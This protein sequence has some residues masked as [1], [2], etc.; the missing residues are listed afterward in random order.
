MVNNTL[1]QE[2]LRECVMSDDIAVSVQNVSKRYLL[3][4][5][6]QD[7]LKQSLFWRFGKHY[8]REFWALRDVSF[9][10]RQGET[11]GIIGRNGAGKSTLLQII[12]GTLAPTEGEVQING[13]I[14]AL[15]ELGSGFNPEY[16]G[17]ENVFMNGAILGVPQVEMEQ[18]FD[19]IVAFADIG[20][21]IDQPV[22]VYSS[23]MFVRLAFAVQAC[24]RP[25]I[26]IVDEALAVGDIGFQRKCYR[27]TE[28]LKKDF[29][30]S[31]ILVTH[32]TNAVVNYCNRAILLNDGEAIHAGSPQLITEL[33][34][35]QMFG[36]DIEVK[37]LEIYG[38]GS[39]SIDEIWFENLAGDR[40]SSSA[41]GQNFY[42][43]Y[44]TE[45]HD[46]VEN[47]VFGMR[48]TTVQGQVLVGANTQTC[49]LDTGSYRTGDS[50]VVRWKIANCLNLGTYFFSCG[51]SYDN[52]DQFLCRKVDATKLVVI[53]SSIES[54]VLT[55]IS[56]VSIHR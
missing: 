25:D 36:E 14:T 4:D 54:G 20:E 39:A 50:V 38:D 1:H 23:G 56:D 34:H 37:S 18:R 30:T 43:C 22:K 48:I 10:L 24:V 16:T 7:R 55:A 46:S 35:K 26:L 8:A 51:C 15:L 42:Y 19:E 53:G 9:D 12:A 27:Y 5:R 31:I 33:Y 47:P 29:E 3:Y 28:T 32:D 13:R 2:E 40:I 45:F 49:R 44:K 21:F 11:L 6:P 17:R 41:I 52:R